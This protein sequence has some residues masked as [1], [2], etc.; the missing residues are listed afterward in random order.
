MKK[1]S[2]V[3]FTFI[4]SIS[5]VQTID[6][7][8]ANLKA[9]LLLAENGNGI[10]Y[11]NGNSFKIDSNNDNEI[12]V[13]EALLVNNLVLNNCGISSLIGLEYFINL[14]HLNFG[15]NS[16]STVDLTPFTNLVGFD[17]Y[18]NNLTN[19]N[20]SNLSQL[21]NFSCNNNQLS[22]LT[23]SNLNSLHTIHCS[24]NQLTTL[25]VSG[26][27]NLTQ[28]NCRNNQLTNLDLNNQ[29]HLNILNCSNNYLASLF[30][31]NGSN[32]SSLNLD[33]LNNPNLQ[34]V[35]ADDFQITQVQN[36]IILY[37]YS[38]CFVNSYC[39][40]VSGGNFYNISGL[41][42]YDEVNDGCD[43]FDIAYPNLKLSIS[44]ETN[45][46]MVF[47]NNVGNY[48]YTVQDG[49]HTIQPILENPTY[50]NVYPTSASITFPTQSSPLLQNFCV[51]PNGLHP[52]LDINVSQINYDYTALPGSNNTYKIVYKNKG[53]NTQSGTINFTFND[54]I[55]DYIYSN[56][57]VL[58]QS[59]N[60]LLWNFSDLKP[61]ESRVIEV[62]FYLNSNTN[63]PSVN[64]GDLLAFTSSINTTA[65]DDTP[66]DNIFILNQVASSV[67]LLNN[68]IIE[69]DKY[70]ILYPNPVTNI[71][72]IET[73]KYTKNESLKFIILL[74]N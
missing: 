39:T 55:L 37:G 70:F 63:L 9:R 44:N 64:D 51:I 12:Q 13:S 25:N 28:L 17:A 27:P 38:N 19:L 68:P 73:N 40:F 16:I 8:D 23:V 33:F 24:Q 42:H 50:F 45:T 29:S 74:G 49:T 61:F 1:F 26:L 14:I 66:S 60:T 67:V 31:K 57:S 54:A 2:L 56:S 7:P 36:K 43:S 22:S 35:C 11:N 53:T 72:T 3:L 21:T 15:N 59:T 46:G 47:G 48:N 41:I 20:V 69:T 65:I 30:I 6:F 32:E 10:A 52:D 4:F 62:T 18:N 34:Y 71:L 58:S 5:K